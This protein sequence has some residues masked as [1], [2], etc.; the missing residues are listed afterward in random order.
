MLIANT[1]IEAK[2]LIELYDADPARVEVVHPGVDL[3][4]FRPVARGPLAGSGCP[5]DADVLL[6]AGRIQP[7][8]A[9]DVLLRAVRRAAR[10]RPGAAVPARRAGRR[11]AVRHRA[12]APRVARRARRR[13]RHRRRRA[14]RAAGRPGRAGRLVRRRDPGLRAVL[15]RVLRAGRRRGPGRRHAGR[16]RRRRRPDHRRARRRTAACW[17]RAT[18]PTTGPRACERVIADA[19]AARASCR[20]GR[21]CAQAALLRVGAH[22]RRGPWTS[23]VPPPA[24]CATTLAA[25]RRE[26][27]GP[28]RDSA[29]DARADDLDVRRRPP[30]GVFSFALPGREEAADPG[31]AR[32]RHARAR[33]ARLRL[34]PARREPRAAST[35][36]CSSATCRMYGVA[37]AVDRLGDIYL[38]GR[39]PLARGHARRARPAARLGADLRRRVVQHDPRARLR[40]LDPQGVGVAQAARRVDRTTSRRSAAG[41]SRVTRRR[42]DDRAPALAVVA[43]YPSATMTTDQGSLQVVSGVDPGLRARAVGDAGATGDD[44]PGR[45]RRRRT[46]SPAAPRRGTASP[47]RS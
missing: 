19:R 35:A 37:F 44:R 46:P 7:L 26:A 41:S 36:G 16:G 1:D 5:Q 28:L 25:V 30:T 31:P 47:S 2:Q 21:P 3:D 17:S 12:R 32:R 43:P 15:Q 33:R 23:T 45:A 20:R 38:D 13:A 42:G 27:D 8:K 18:S 9:P 14:L 22:R 6:F 24:R 10:A 34:P 11:R 4:V 29:H 39:L 40:L